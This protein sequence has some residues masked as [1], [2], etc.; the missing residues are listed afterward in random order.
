M[1]QNIAINWE[2]QHGKMLKQS[3][4]HKCNTNKYNFKFW[5]ENLTK[6][7]DSYDTSLN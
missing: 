5:N 7:Y 4:E 2:L 1:K 6:M 3:A